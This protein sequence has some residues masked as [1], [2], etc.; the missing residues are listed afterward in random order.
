[1]FRIIDFTIAFFGLIIV[2]P[3]MIFIIF[4]LLISKINPVFKQIRLG[5][6][7]KQF[8]LYKFR[9]MKINTLSQPTHLVSSNQITII[10]NILRKSK[11]DEL[12]ID[13]EN[14]IR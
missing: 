8:V 10:G 2:L 6:N 7:K 12:G 13:Y 5:K 1:M 11:L 14:E 3:L 4:V 9:S